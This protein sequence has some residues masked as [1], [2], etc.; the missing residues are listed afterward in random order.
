MVNQEETKRSILHVHD[1]IAS[2]TINTRLINAMRSH[3][4]NLIGMSLDF[5]DVFIDDSGD[6]QYICKVEKDILRVIIKKNNLLVFS[7]AKQDLLLSFEL[8]AF[9]GKNPNEVEPKESWILSLK[10]NDEL[11]EAILKL[12][13]ELGIAPSN[14]FYVFVA[15]GDWEKPINF[16]LD[17][18]GDAME[19]ISRALRNYDYQINCDF[20]N[21]RG[22]IECRSNSVMQ[23]IWIEVIGTRGLIEKIRNS[24]ESHLELER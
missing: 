8:E 24:L 5:I 9:Q 21:E 3:L 23:K 18:W 20:K 17:E 11:H 1:R 22:I 10:N 2:G 13:D 14:L 4:E 6:V 16:K 7:E 12:Q 15:W 19:D